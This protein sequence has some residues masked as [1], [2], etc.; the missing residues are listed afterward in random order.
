VIRDTCC[1]RCRQML[2]VGMDMVYRS[3]PREAL[4]QLC[5]DRDPEIRRSWRPSLRW[6]RERRRVRP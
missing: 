6:E 1:A 2:R 3:R 5:A 4:C